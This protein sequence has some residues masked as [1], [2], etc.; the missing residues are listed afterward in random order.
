M[1]LVT[2]PLFVYVA[3]E[4]Q[5]TKSKAAQATILSFDPALSTVKVGEN[6]TLGI[7]LNP[8]TGVDA[9]QVSFVKLSISFDASKFTTIS[10][11]LKA[12]PDPA[13][14]LT[15][16]VDNAKYEQGKATLSLSIGANPEKAITTKTKIAIFQLKATNTTNP[17]IPNITFDPAPDTQVLSIDSNSQTS[18]NVL[19]SAIHATVTVASATTTATTPGA[20]S[21]SAPGSSPPS[22]SALDPTTPKTGGLASSSFPSSLSTAPTCS[23]LD[24][25]GPANGAAPYSLTFTAIGNDSDGTIDKISFNFGDAVEDLTSGD[26]IGTNSVNGQMLHTYKTPGVYH[27]YALLTDNDDNLSAQQD[28]CAKTITVN[29]ADSAQSLQPVPN[30]TVNQSLPPTGDGKIIFGLGALG[31]IFAIIGGALL[32]L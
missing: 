30:T 1:V 15:T 18:D 23:S 16:V 8:G 26:G 32:L 21:T 14:A 10:G 27:A 7:V 24:I 22:S 3:Q 19:S 4:R 28:A 20:A 12:N 31:A 25:N 5:Q 6:L 9:N 17:A 13:N 11:S 2:I 29:P